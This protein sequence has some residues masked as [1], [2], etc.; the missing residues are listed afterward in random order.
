[1]ELFHITSIRNLENILSSGVIL[2]KNRLL[3]SDQDHLS[4]AYEG[5]QERRSL[6]SVPCSPFGVLHDYIPFY[7]APRSPMLYAIHNGRVEGYREGQAKII[8]LVTEVSKVVEGQIAFIFSD[9]HPVM[10]YT[11]FYNDLRKLDQKIDWEVMQ[12]RYWY[13]T[14][15]EPDRKRRR[16]AEFLVYKCF[17]INLLTTVGVFNRE[18]LEDVTYINERFDYVIDCQIRRDWYY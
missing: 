10:N 15:E 2:S 4:I 8:Y 17:P 18:I 9:G 12:A 3:S 5:I 7:F 14:Q 1:M 16:Q 13:D 6:K 11:I